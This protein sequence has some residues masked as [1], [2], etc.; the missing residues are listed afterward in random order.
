MPHLFYTPFQFNVT[1]ASP[2]FNL[3]PIA[4][5]TDQGWVPS[6]STPDCIATANWSTRSIGATMTFQFYGSGITFEGNVKG[7]MS[8]QLW[9]DE[10]EELWNPSK[11][12]LL[13]FR[14]PLLGD[15]AM[16][17]ITLKVLDASPDAELT[18]SQARVD[19]SSFADRLWS[20]DRWAISNYKLQASPLSLAD[21]FWASD[22]WAISSNDV[23]LSYTGFAQQASTTQ[24]RLQTTSVSSKAGDTMSMQFNG[25]TFLIHGPCGPTNGLMKVTVDGHE[26]TVNTSKP[27]VSDDCVLFQA[28]AE[29]PSYMHQMTVENVD[30]T[31]LGIS[32]VEFFKIDLHRREASGRLDASLAMLVVAAIILGLTPVLSCIYLANSKQ[33]KRLRRMFK[34]MFS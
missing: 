1:P 12:T 32:R 14:A 26:S 21:H 8:I 19:G 29:S 9:Q 15:L 30:G 18:V 5:S 34:E 16:H 17:N 4:L 27:L 20:S 28:W 31:I 10:V 24:S 25:S 22:R 23:Q 33:G 3:S 6:C 11:N 13:E 7:N 2:P